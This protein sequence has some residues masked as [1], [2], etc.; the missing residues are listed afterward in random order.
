MV[1]AKDIPSETNMWGE[2]FNLR[3]KYYHPNL[4]DEQCTALLEEATAIHRKYGETK[5]CHDL[6]WSV[7]SEY[8]RVYHELR[9]KEELAS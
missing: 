8:D 3:K 6:I 5:F 7:L 4:T 2:I 1:L 9:I